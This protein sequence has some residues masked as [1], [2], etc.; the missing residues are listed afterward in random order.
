MPPRLHLSRPVTQN[1]TRHI[2]IG[3][4][5]WHYAHWKGSFYPSS[6]SSDQ[7]LGFYAERYNT[8]EIDGSFYRLPPPDVVREWY[9]IVPDGFL[10]AMKASRYLTHMKKLNDAREPLQRFLRCAAH[11]KEK[12]GPLL[13][14][15]PPW[16]RLN[17]DRLRSFLSLLSSDYSYTM[18]FREPSW[19]QPEVLE[20]LKRHNVA[21]CI[22]EIGGKQSPITTTADLVYVRL[23]GPTKAYGGDYSEPTLKSWARRIEKWRG[24]HRD[25]Y[26][27][28]DNDE[29][30]YAAKNAEQLKE[31][32]V[33]E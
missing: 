2:R 15:L 9:R 6:M 3:T 29:A 24:E 25:V 7:F 26:L 14:Q 8:V 11:L 5:G 17:L 33:D 4:S 23:H 30:A 16:W 13:F 27:Y 31:L 18:E 10:F 28:F 32:V 19:F 21:L 12:L 22:Y 1:R 20:L